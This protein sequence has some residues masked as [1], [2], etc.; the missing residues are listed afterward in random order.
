MSSSVH[1]EWNADERAFVLR[2]SVVLEHSREA[3]FEFF[4]DAFQLERI[5]PPW[6]NFKIQTPAPI[7]IRTG[8]LIDYTIRLRG[9]PIRWKTEISSWDPP[10]SFTDRQLKGPYLLWEHL[11]TFE[12]VLEGTL[13]TDEVR[14]RVPGGRL[15]NWLIVQR[16]LERIFKYRRDKMLE[17]FP[18]C[19]ARFAV[20]PPGSSSRSEAKAQAP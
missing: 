20:Q 19:S 4:S 3:L 11:H 17:L 7:Q 8:C 13:A 18:P 10:F 5:T 2:S 12:T 6:L 14:Y 1:V 9:I 16:D 15:V